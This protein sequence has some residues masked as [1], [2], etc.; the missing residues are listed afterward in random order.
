MDG[1]TIE[2]NLLHQLTPK[3]LLV[4]HEVNC[5]WTGDFFVLRSTLAISPKIIYIT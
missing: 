1:K 2:Q 4:N 3:A 5:Q